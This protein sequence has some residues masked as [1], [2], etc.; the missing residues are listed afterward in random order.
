[1]AP[2]KPPNAH[3][4]HLRVDFYDDDVIQAFM[5]VRGQNFYD[6][7]RRL[8]MYYIWWNRGLKIIEVWG[9][10]PS[11][12]NNNPIDVLHAELEVCN[13]NMSEYSI[14]TLV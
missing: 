5:G 13:K 10:Y 8:G 2:Y 6:L 11:F 7:T 3:Y 9:P 4:A 12:K 1:M 14:R